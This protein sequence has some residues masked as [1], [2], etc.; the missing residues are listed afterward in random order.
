MNPRYAI[1]PPAQSGLIV[2]ARS[3]IAELGFE[4][5]AGDDAFSLPASFSAPC[6]CCGAPRL[7]ALE[8]LCPECEAGGAA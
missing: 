4:P 7:S 6:V 1:P 2:I 5:E 8:D 3:Y